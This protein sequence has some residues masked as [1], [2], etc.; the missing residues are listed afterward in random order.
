MKAIKALVAGITLA[1]STAA[2]ATPVLTGSETS[3]QD[4]IA[5]LYT[6]AGSNPAAAPNVNT[7]QVAETGWFQIGA[8]SGSFATMVIEL[9][10]LAATNTFGIYDVNNPNQK[11]EIFSGSK[12]G[13]DKAAI[14]VDDSYVFTLNISGPT[15]QFSSSKFGYYLGTG[16]GTFFYSD[17]FLNAGEDHMVAFQGNGKDYIKL[18]KS[19][20][21]YWLDTEYLLAWEDMPFA[22]SD[23]D[24]QDMVLMVESVVPSAVPEPTSLSL[25][26]ASLFGLGLAGRR[27]KSNQA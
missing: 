23:K 10:G 6:N 17:P 24:Y 16:V 12:T 9:A 3:L 19:A 14:S 20:P 8:T 1:A 15:K 11:L 27:R 7:D 22:N 5:A 18:P 25:L 21:G 2:F 13:G 26:G 4:V